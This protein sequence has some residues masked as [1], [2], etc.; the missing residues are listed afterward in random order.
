M[1]DSTT[2]STIQ[3]KPRKVNLSSISFFDFPFLIIFTKIFPCFF[4]SGNPPHSPFR[5]ALSL[6]LASSTLAPS[7][8]MTYSSCPG[9]D[10]V[11]R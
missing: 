4:S 6:S 7:G 1:T 10:H 2:Y 9:M 11:S 5:K 3:Y 8:R